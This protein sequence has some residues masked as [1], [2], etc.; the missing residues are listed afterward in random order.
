MNERA[1]VAQRG[2]EFVDFGMTGARHLVERDLADLVA[3]DQD[4]VGGLAHV[5]LG[6]GDEEEAEP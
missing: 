4:P 3:V 1:L 6:A 2:D 5:A